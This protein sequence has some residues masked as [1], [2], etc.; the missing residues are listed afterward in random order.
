MILYK[1]KI[2][3]FA[4]LALFIFTPPVVDYI[5]PVSS[6]AIGT[7]IACGIAYCFLPWKLPR[8][9]LLSTPI[10]TKIYLLLFLIV[11]HFAVSALLN[12]GDF[13]RFIGSFVALIIM[14]RVSLAIIPSLYCQNP[15]FGVRVV[16]ISMLI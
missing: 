13:G 6:F 10:N 12:R 4:L 14:L 5:F 2:V 7:L 16:F 8:S 1:S 11:A 9:G 3:A 15:A